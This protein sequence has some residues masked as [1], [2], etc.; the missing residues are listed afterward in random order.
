M[1]DPLDVFRDRCLGG[2]TDLD[3]TIHPRDEAW[4]ALAAHRGTQR[5][6][7][8]YLRDGYELTQTVEQVARWRFGADLRSV[9][10]LEVGCGHGRDVRHLVRRFGAVGVTAADFQDGAVTFCTGRFEVRGLALTAPEELLTEEQFDLIVVPALL[11]REPGAELERW[12]EVL[13]DRLT[14]S[15]LLAFGA[16]HAEEA[17]L[18]SRIARAAGHD[19]HGRAPLALWRHRDLHLVPRRPDP[20]VADFR[21]DHGVIWSLDVARYTP[22]GHL[23]LAGW[24]TTADGAGAPAEVRVTLDGLT[25]ATGPARV[26][27]PQVAALWG[28]ATLESGFWFLVPDATRFHGDDSELIV[29]AHVGEDAACLYAGP[30]ASA[31]TGG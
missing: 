21:F 25:V 11:A 7:M 26:T 9:R 23:E 13:I 31:L 24:A 6:T 28:D 1:P 16:D 29:T 15:G 10:L 4:A 14:P 20:S 22:E 12:L 3:E 18:A 5:A 17:A 19:I 30:L 27:R 2:G 8:D